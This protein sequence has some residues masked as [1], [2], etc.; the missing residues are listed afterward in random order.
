[1]LLHLSE[2]A[3]H[4]SSRSTMAVFLRPKEAAKHAARLSKQQMLFTVVAAARSQ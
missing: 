2:H 1:M 4:V 3:M